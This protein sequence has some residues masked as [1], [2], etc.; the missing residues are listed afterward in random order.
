MCTLAPAGYRP[1]LRYPG[2]KQKTADAIL[3]RFPRRVQAAHL[4]GEI[5]CYAEPFVGSGTIAMTMLPWLPAGTA[6]IL[7]DTDPG[8]VAIWRA[9]YEDPAGLARRL[10]AFTPSVDEFFRLKALDGRDD[11]DAVELAVRKIA[12]HQMSFSGLGAKGGPIGGRGQA[13]RYSAGCRFNPERHAADIAAQHRL[14]RS[15]AS[16]EAVRGDFAATLARVPDDRRGF[17]YLDP[18]YYLRGK[19]LYV[20]NMDDAAHRRL[21]DTLRAAA[22]DWVLSYDDHPRVRQLYQGWA[23]IDRFEMTASIDNKCNGTR[24]KATELVITPRRDGV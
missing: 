16:F 13:S 20:H 14:L 2:S 5:A 17:A 4:R 22:F 6:V 8:V 10:M 23:A 7:G 24:R 21:A 9:V 3:G 19:K 15:F 18:P 11:A 1:A 12:L